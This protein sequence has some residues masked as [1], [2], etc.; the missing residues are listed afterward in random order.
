LGNTYVTW[1]TLLLYINNTNNHPRTL[2]FNWA[3]KTWT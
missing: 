3:V 2:C 1:R